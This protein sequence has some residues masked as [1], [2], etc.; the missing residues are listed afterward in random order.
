M[1]VGSVISMRASIYLETP[2][3]QEKS[4]LFQESAWGTWDSYTI[5]SYDILC[6]DSHE[7]QVTVLFMT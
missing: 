1:A 6:S 3:V 7:R 5:E 2:V 4:L